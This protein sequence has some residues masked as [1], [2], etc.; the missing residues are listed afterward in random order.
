MIS[1]KMW[2][3][4]NT[5]VRDIIDKGLEKIVEISKNE[6]PVRA[7]ICYDNLPVFASDENGLTE[8][9]E[10]AFERILGYEK[11]DRKD[12]M[13][14]HR[15]SNKILKS[16]KDHMPRIAPYAIPVVKT[17]GYLFVGSLAF[18]L[19]GCGGSSGGSS[20]TNQQITDITNHAP[21]IT[22]MPNLEAEANSWY[23]YN[24]DAFDADNDSLTYHLEQAP[25]DMMID[26]RDGH[27]CYY[28]SMICYVSNLLVCI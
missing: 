24:F 14:S 20:N 26:S 8:K 19:S 13:L 22:S 12:F 25:S 15:L 3:F 28:W 11:A 18:A 6:N 23:V 21:I 2:N 16:I 17:A 5:P 7:S 9:A 4:L 1:K 10:G 27:R